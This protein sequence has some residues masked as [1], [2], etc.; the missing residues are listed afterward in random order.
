L[1]LKV[2]RHCS[3]HGLALNVNMDLAPF[4][5]IHPCGYAGLRTADMRTLGI[6][7]NMASVTQSLVGQLQQQL[8]PIA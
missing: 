6:E 1:G 8:T 3:Y 4:Q 7:D 5:Q 2:T